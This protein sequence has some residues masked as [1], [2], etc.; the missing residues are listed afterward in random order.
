M[1]YSP[2]TPYKTK[3]LLLIPQTVTAKGSTKKIVSSENA[4]PIHCRFQS[5]GGTEKTENGVL[6]VED[7]ANI[8]M[9]Y[10]PDLTAGCMLEDM[11][12]KRYE[13]LGTPENVEMANRV[14]KFKIR[15]IS[16]GA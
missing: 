4:S 11:K 3:M 9:W 10:H 13:I 2:R 16:G 1:N 7:T 5:F 15:A 12:G 8:E 6:L 14:M